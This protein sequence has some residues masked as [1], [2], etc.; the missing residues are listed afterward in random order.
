MLRRL[1]WLRVG[2]ALRL[3]PRRSLRRAGRPRVLTMFARSSRGKRRSFRHWQRRRRGSQR[4]RPNMR[5]M[6]SR[7]QKKKK[8]ALAKAAAL[9]AAPVAA[10]EVA[11]GPGSSDAPAAAAPVTAMASGAVGSSLG[12]TSKSS[13][14]A[15][16]SALV[17][18]AVAAADSAL[19]KAAVAAADSALAKAAALVAAAVAAARGSAGRVLRM[20][21]WRWLRSRPGHLGTWVPAL[22]RLVLPCGQAFAVPA[23]C[24]PSVVP[25]PRSGASAPGSFARPR[26]LRCCGGCR[27]GGVPYC[28][29]GP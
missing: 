7:R 11:G 29:R 23:A 27:G 16:A 25:V 26:G 21:P 13:A 5:V 18:A 28:S 10:S 17:A 8:S 6:S 24:G 22:G 3:L 20:L 4:R 2:Q 19:A 12:A 15:T 1:S 9:V 14:L